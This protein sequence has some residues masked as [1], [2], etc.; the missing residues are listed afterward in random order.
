MANKTANVDDYNIGVIEQKM[1]R[2]S[3]ETARKLGETDKKPA[4]KSNP[5]DRKK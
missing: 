3:R 1:Q 5:A 2:M 4:A